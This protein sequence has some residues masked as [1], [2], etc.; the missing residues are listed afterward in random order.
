MTIQMWEHA[1]M[2]EPVCLGEM[3]GAHVRAAQYGLP[4]PRRPTIREGEV[5]EGCQGPLTSARY[6]FGVASEVPRCGSEQK[7]GGGH[8]ED[9]CP[10]EGAA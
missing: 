3:V 4:C 5:W 1:Q 2:A 8:G 7:D 9:E 6:T 10:R